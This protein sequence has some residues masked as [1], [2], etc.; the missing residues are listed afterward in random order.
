MLGAATPCHF[1][2]K[3]SPVVISSGDASGEICFRPGAALDLHLSGGVSIFAILLVNN[4]IIY[5]L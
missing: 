2:T 3:H 5:S 4:L 1:E